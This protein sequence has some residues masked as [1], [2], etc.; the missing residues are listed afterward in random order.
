MAYP[1]VGKKIRYIKT[2]CNVVSDLAQADID[3]V[4]LVCFN[5]HIELIGAVMPQTVC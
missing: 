1:Y 4:L 5:I 3:R 2:Y